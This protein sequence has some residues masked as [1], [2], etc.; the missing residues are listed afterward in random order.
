MSDVRRLAIR[1][2]IALV[3]VVILTW[4]LLVGTTGTAGSLSDQL[5]SG[6]RDQ[7]SSGLGVV[8]ERQAAPIHR[9]AP[10]GPPPPQRPMPV[11]AW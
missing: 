4:C 6:T 7:L 3:P 2:T 10:V 5:V 1:V 9:A 8:A 11:Q